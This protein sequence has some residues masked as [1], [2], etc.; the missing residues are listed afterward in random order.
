MWQSIKIQK[1][2]NSDIIMVMDECPKNTKDY[3]TIKNSMELS[4][5]WAKRSKIEFAQN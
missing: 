1:K 4:T 5:I 2:L 3:N